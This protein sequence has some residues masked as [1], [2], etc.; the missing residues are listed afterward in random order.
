MKQLIIVTLLFLSTHAIGQKV[1]R[2]EVY[3]LDPEKKSIIFWQET[4]YAMLNSTEFFV[5]DKDWAFVKKTLKRQD[6][7]LFI[8]FPC[9]TIEE[10][11]TV[12]RSEV[13]WSKG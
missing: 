7:V 12:T 6:V 13:I 2:L 8:S 5:S 11:F 10:I 9:N 4:E 1:Y 3:R